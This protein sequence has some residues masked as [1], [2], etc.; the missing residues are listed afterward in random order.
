MATIESGVSLNTETWTEI[1]SAGN[2]NIQN[3][4]GDV[5]YLMFAASAPSDGQKSGQIV[6]P[7]SSTIYKI[8]AP[9]GEKL[10]GLSRTVNVVLSV[11]PF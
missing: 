3:S 6:L 4:T 11:S 8:S 1:I 7:P 2:A 9:S 10:Y 5:V